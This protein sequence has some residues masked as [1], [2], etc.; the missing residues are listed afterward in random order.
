MLGSIQSV[1]FV[2]C[3]LYLCCKSLS[4][5]LVNLHQNLFTP[6]PFNFR[7]RQ[8]SFTRIRMKLLYLYFFSASFFA[9]F[10]DAVAS[11]WSLATEYL[12]NSYHMQ[13]DQRGIRY[14]P[15]PKGSATSR[16]T[17]ATWRRDAIRRKVTVRVSTVDLRTIKNSPQV[18]LASQISGGE[19]WRALFRRFDLNQVP[20]FYNEGDAGTPTALNPS[21]QQDGILELCEFLAAGARLNGGRAVPARVDRG[22]EICLR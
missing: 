21:S 17:S 18:H 3:C 8:A 15:P 1:S 19:E 22:R 13:F 4:H 20:S 16:D 6:M 10:A 11:T 9:S 14:S 2:A 7:N 5:H 12:R